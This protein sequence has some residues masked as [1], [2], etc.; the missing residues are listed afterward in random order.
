MPPTVEEE[1]VRFTAGQLL[2][3][4]CRFQMADN[5]IRPPTVQWLNSAGSVQ[6]DTSTFSFSPLLTSDGGEYTCNVTINI[7]ELN[8]L[9]SDDDTIRLTVQSKMLNL[10]H[11]CYILHYDHLHMYFPMQFLLHL[12]SLEKLVCHSMAQCTSSHVL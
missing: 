1:D 11:V 7:P 4:V 2:S 3:I 9:L 5:L 8:I 12:L 6:S 10:R